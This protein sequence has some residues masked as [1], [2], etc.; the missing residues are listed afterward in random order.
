MTESV[1]PVWRGALACAL[2][3]AIVR[4]VVILLPPEDL[5]YGGFV[6]N[7]EWL[8][9]NVAVELLNGPL[10]PIQDH[11]L[12][13]WGGVVVVGAMAAPLFALF[14][15]VLPALRLACVPFP[16][17]EAAAAFALLHRFAGARAAWAGGLMV[18]IAAPGPILD[19]VLAQGTHQHFHALVLAWMWFA[20][21]VRARRGGPIAHGSLTLALGLILYYGGSALVALAVALELVLDRSWWRD[22]KL[23]VARV[24]G[25]AIGILPVLLARDR[26]GESTLGIYGHTPAGLAFGGGSEPI[27][28]TID[29][30]ASIVPDAFWVRGSAGHAIG[31]A[32]TIALVGLWAVACWTQRRQRDPAVVA[33]LAYPLVFT[34]VWAMSPLVRGSEDHVIAVRYALPLIGVL[35]LTSALAVAHVARTR[36]RVAT[37]IPAVFV[38]LALATLAPKLE[39]SAMR[40]NWST[41]GARPEGV[42]KIHLWRNGA[43]PVALDRFLATVD[44]RRTGEARTAVLRELDRLLEAGARGYARLRDRGEPGPDPAPWWTALERVRAREES[45]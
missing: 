5:K 29:L 4:I 22:A 8:R 36:P 19:S 25:L 39:P 26:S 13:L 10:V 9:G 21:E 11:A 43:D 27:A 24:V 42:A 35:T 23:V 17:I 37:A 6:W 34:G 28:R 38:A 41:P 15:P 7:E 20:S 45:P 44:E 30:Y 31:V 3:A 16:M 40:A 1:R 32:W 14:G 12:G 18:A 2:I 33:L